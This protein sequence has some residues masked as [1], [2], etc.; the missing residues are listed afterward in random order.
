[1]GSGIGLLAIIALAAPTA[2]ASQRCH[3]PGDEGDGPV[4][5]NVV[6]HGLT[7]LTADDLAGD[8]FTTWQKRGRLPHT[9]GGA[10]DGPIYRCRYTPS[11]RDGYI[12]V[13]CAHGRRYFTARI[14]AF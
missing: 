8:I 9:V 11:K 2:H 6:A 3:Y 12:A 14:W 13:K 7:C 4:I 5:T 10:A 1:V